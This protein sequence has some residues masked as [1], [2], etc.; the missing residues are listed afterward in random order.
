MFD[1]PTPQ[2][3]TQG[4]PGPVA[5][6]VNLPVERP[7]ASQP[8]PEDILASFDEAQPKPAATPL[9]PRFGTGPAPLPSRVAAP[10]F[11][12]AA[13][14]AQ[15]PEA[16]EPFFKR[17]QRVFVLVAIL[18]VGGGVLAAGGW[19]GY[20]VF[21]ANRQSPAVNQNTAAQPAGNVANTNQ[22]SSGQNTNAGTNQSVNAAPVVAPIAPA[23]TDRDGVTDEEE[24]LYGTDPTKVDTDGD[25][26]KDGDEVAR[27]L[28]PNGPGK[29]SL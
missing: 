29:L 24:A 28:N 16:K 20:R 6:P 7:A 2:P 11:R 4:A 23:D 26:V 10:S 27:G 9:I 13:A 25:K 21:F 5:P 15:P 19:Y 17:Y 12:A 8:E 14:P 3:Q 18:L 1:A 22:T